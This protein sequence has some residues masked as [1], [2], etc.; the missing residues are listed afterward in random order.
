MPLLLLVV[1]MLPVIGW[2][3][4]NN[5]FL[6]LIGVK[7]LNV[8]IWG[9]WSQSHFDWKQQVLSNVPSTQ[10]FL[11]PTKSC[12]R[13]Y[14]QWTSDR[15]KGKQLSLMHSEGQRLSPISKTEYCSPI[16]WKK[17]MLAVVERCKTQDLSSFCIWHACA[18]L[19]NQLLV[20]NKAA[21][22]GWCHILTECVPLHVVFYDSAAG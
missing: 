16:C 17:L 11:V 12:P 5:H 2:E 19:Q 4:I 10:W 9:T 3:G 8:M 13:R 21:E 18:L 1:V 22:T 7:R 14:N 6:K 15:I 20:G